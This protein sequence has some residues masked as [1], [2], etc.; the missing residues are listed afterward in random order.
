MP[1]IIFDNCVL[2]NFALSNS[3]NVI[4]HLYSNTS[5]I[6][7][8]VMAENLRGIVKGHRE[9]AYIREAVQEGWLREIREVP[10]KISYTGREQQYLLCFACESPKYPSWITHK[11]TG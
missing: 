9:L 1:E 3:F 10:P 7:N 2:S 5:Y 11:D 8:L 4:K 6:T